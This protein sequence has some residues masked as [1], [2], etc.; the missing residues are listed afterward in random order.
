MRM[1]L[2]S[3]II[4]LNLLMKSPTKINKVDFKN[5]GIGCC[6]WFF[7]LNKKQFFYFNF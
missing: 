4:L 1:L 6:F 5:Y 2:L 7:F 3:I